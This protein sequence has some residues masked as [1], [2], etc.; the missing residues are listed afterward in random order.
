MNTLAKQIAGTVDAMK[1]CAKEPGHPWTDKHAARLD[2]MEKELPSGSG[3]DCGTKIDRD[4]TDAEKIV[5]HLSFHHM[6]GDGYYN[7]WTDHTITARAS[8]IHGLR[9]TISGR[10]RN[11]IK[12]YL[13]D[14][15]AAA[16]SA[17]YEHND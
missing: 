13:H 14:V 4:R 10:D 11:G 7:G 12:D 17:P 9:L 16:L 1:H 3:I 6:N 2:Q 5:L 15:Y 8:L